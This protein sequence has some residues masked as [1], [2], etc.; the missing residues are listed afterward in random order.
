MDTDV[1]TA[2]I[3]LLGVIIT[4]VGGVVTAQLQQARK[5]VGVPNGQGNVVQMLERVLGLLHD[6]GERITH[7]EHSQDAI[8]EEVDEIREA[9]F[10]NEGGG[11]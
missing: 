8:R 5:A 11:S 7:L 3:A 1:T 6:Q 9:T 4:V 10:G 2:L